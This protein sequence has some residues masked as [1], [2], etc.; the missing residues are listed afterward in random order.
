VM[1]QFVI[2]CPPVHK[3]Q[4]RRLPI[5]DSHKTHAIVLALAAARSESIQSRRSRRCDQ[6]CPRRTPPMRNAVDFYAPAL[7]FPN[8]E[9]PDWPRRIRPVH[10]PIICEIPHPSTSVSAR[11]EPRPDSVRPTSFGPRWAGKHPRN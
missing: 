5:V 9:E 6:R 10:P 4:V 1:M 2:I 8:L 7:Q 3:D 11:K